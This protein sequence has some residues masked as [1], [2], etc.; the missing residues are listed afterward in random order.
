MSRYFYIILTA[1][2]LSVSAYIVALK[3]DDTHFDSPSAR[4]E[5]SNQM[6]TATG[7]QRLSTKGRDDN[8]V[9]DCRVGE[10]FRQGKKREAVCKHEHITHH[11]E[12]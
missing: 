7:K 9:N 5:S 6:M 2:Y 4:Q 10:E 8:R 12:K 3:A 11:L 1:L